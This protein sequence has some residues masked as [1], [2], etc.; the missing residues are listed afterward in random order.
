LNNI[1]AQSGRLVRFNIDTFATPTVSMVDI[2][3]VEANAIGFYG[4]FTDG[5]Y[6]YLP[7]YA[8]AAGKHGNLARIDLQNFTST[9]VT[10]LN[11]QSV[12]TAYAGFIGGFTDG[13]YGYLI[14]YYNNPGPAGRVVRVDLTNFS[15]TPAAVTSVNLASIDP[16]LVG[17][18][19]GF[20]DGRY[21]YV[22][23]AGYSPLNG[24][25][26]RIDLANFTTGGVTVLDLTTVNPALRG[27][28]GGFQDGRYGYLVPYYNGVHHGNFVRIDLGNFS[29]SGVTVLDVAGVDASL[30]G[31]LGGFTDG[32]Y[33]WLAP[34]NGTKTARIDLANFSASGVRVVDFA[35]IDPS[36]TGFH[37]AFSNGKYG[38]MVPSYKLAVSGFY[39]K[40]VRLQLHQGAGTP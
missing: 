18:T 29:A 31:F 21:A 40:V 7:P 32:R 38:V 13:R 24:K 37:G 28:A 16:Q 11:L 15:A 26:A 6:G 3:A 30:V 35:T 34:Y 27:F 23:G 8:N 39:Q 25:V 33:A 5:R 14:Q 1:G 2:G 10:I 17:L 4:G 22:F 19:G 20:T 36:L 9:G 12:D